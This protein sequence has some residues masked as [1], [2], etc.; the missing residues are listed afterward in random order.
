MDREIVE[1]VARIARLKLTDEELEKYSSDLSEILEYFKV[2]DEAPGTES[3]G[4]NPVE[5]AD[6]LRE[7]EPCM[8]IDPDVLL[9]DMKTYEDYVRGPRL[10]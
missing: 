3:F 9:R 2:L 6:I 10:S 4:F 5:I 1:R 8:E 7:D